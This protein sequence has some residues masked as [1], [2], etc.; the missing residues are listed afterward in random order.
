MS[1][2][3][4]A[5]VGRTLITILSGTQGAVADAPTPAPVL[6]SGGKPYVH[7]QAS[8]ATTWVVNH[9]RGYRPLVAVLNPAGAE[10]TAEVTHVSDNQLTVSF[11]TAR[12]G[13]V[14]AE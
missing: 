14:L 8:A 12:T 1:G 13:Q 2:L 7:A 3:A 5:P 11:S 4:F 9:N 6:A 10:I